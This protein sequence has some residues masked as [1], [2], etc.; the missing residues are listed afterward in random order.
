MGLAAGVAGWIA[1]GGS[2][3]SREPHPRLF[4]PYTRGA[5]RMH[6]GCTTV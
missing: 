2:E 4:T 5:H 3:L 6:E 1:L